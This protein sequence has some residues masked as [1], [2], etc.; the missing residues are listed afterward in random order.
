MHTYVQHIPVWKR[1]IFSIRKATECAKGELTF[2]C[3]ISCARNYSPEKLGVL[4]EAATESDVPQE[5]D[6]VFY[7]GACE[8]GD[9]KKK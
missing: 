1:K 6:F 9:Q 4:L 7:K 2:V 5:R 8:Q 3:N